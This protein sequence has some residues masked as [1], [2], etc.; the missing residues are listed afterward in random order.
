MKN[1]IF[2]SCVLSCLTI[3]SQND[4]D[5]NIFYKKID[6]LNI[7]LQQIKIT[8]ANFISAEI[9]KNIVAFD[10]NTKLD[11]LYKLS[12]SYL[13]FGFNDEAKKILL[14]AVP[15]IKH[16]NNNELNG[17]LYKQ[18][19]Y[20]G[21]IE[22]D[23][24]S[25]TKYYELSKIYFSKSTNSNLQFNLDLL[26]YKMYLYL[27][28][29]DTAI[30]ISTTCYVKSLQSKDSTQT[31]NALGALIDCYK[32]TKDYKNVLYYSKK[33]A[34]ISAANYINSHSY[35]LE[36]Q[37]SVYINL[38]YY[39]S[40]T[41]FFKKAYKAVAEDIS[42][43]HDYKAWRLNKIGAELYALT[44]NK[45]ISL[46]Y[47]HRSNQYSFQNNLQEESDYLFF[48]AGIYEKLGDAA[49]A[50]KN[51][52]LYL[53]LKEEI[54][55][56]EAQKYLIK[57][58]S[59][60]ESIEKEKKINSLI[61]E[62]QEKEVLL[63]KG[64]LKRKFTLFYFSIVFIFSILSLFI[65]Y[66]FKTKK[67]V[68]TSENLRFQSVIDAQEKERIRIAKDLHDGLGQNICAIKM[69]CSNSLDLE[70]KA[71]LKLLTIIDATY[72]EIRTISHNMMPN[73]LLN[74]GL[75]PAIKEMIANIGDSST[76]QFDFEYDFPNKIEENVSISI[77]RIL[78]ESISNIIKHSQAS[79]VKIKLGQEKK[80]HVLL[81]RDNG[82]GSK[83]LSL[84]TI[85]NQS[86]HTYPKMGIGLK[87][88]LSRTTMIKGNIY[89]DSSDKQ[90]TS[91]KIIF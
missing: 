5:K 42:S 3:Y 48:K 38:K 90:G 60:Y 6:T 56:K 50:L 17:K 27:K 82:I 69:I 89:I 8:K 45:E 33:G 1:F 80:N 41:L 11:V 57:Y 67:I 59:L 51:L 78:Q 77:Y 49:L 46:K 34:K 74:N 7:V 47:L 24:L 62:N 14:K 66:S 72:E 84:A 28:K 30:K 85:I 70:D 54:D 88:I 22:Y 79:T 16:S 40:A 25:A 39:D 12:L 10:T 19:C 76:I 43:F 75:V 44:K 18:L 13:H 86:E 68:T 20:L 91:L 36:E 61:K 58:T 65:W 31:I 55:K 83:D 26:I 2:L 87:N 63:Y 21:I 32:A 15:D 71:N 73:V 64:D 52:K 37:A 4:I 29:Y 23:I 81:I 53:N 9:Q 35:F